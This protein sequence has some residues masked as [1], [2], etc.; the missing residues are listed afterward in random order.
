[1]NSLIRTPLAALFCATLGIPAAFAQSATFDIDA[2]GSVSSETDG[3]LILRYLFGMRGS[4]LVDNAVGV[5]ATRNAGQIENVLAGLVGG[6]PP[7]LDIDGNGVADT[8]TDGVLI[9]RYMMNFRGTGLIQGAIGIGA[10]RTSAAQ[11]EPLLSS[12]NGSAQ[13][14]PGDCTVVAS[15]KSSPGTTLL[16]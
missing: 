6:S 1:M 10:T 13:Q 12:L 11:V 4:S 9:L 8:L 5:G 15:P 14:I 2:N 16:P 3:V 7:T